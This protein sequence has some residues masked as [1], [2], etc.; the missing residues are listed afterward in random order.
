MAKRLFRRGSGPGLRALIFMALSIALIVVDQRV[1]TFH[2]FRLRISSTAA[3]P[4]ELLV[5][6][7]V[8]FVRWL[9]TSMTS[10]TNLVHENEELRVREILLQSKLQKLL[11][12][13]E[14][15]AH[16]KQLLQSTSEI[17]GRVAVARLLAVSL[18]PNLQQVIL[19]KGSHD[20][21]YAGQPV[22]DAF[23]VMGQVTG[24]GP[25]TSKVMLITDKMS[26]VPVED[27]RNGVR[28]IAVGT[29]ES[30]ELALLNV[31]LENGIQVGDLF[32]TSG[33]GLCYPVGYPVG[34]VVKIEHQGDSPTE[35]ILLSPMAHLDRTQQV[36][37]A[38]LNETDLTK[39]VQ[40]QLTAPTT[41]PTKHPHKKVSKKNSASAV[42]TDKK[43]AHPHNSK[44]ADPHASH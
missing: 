14:E 9:N 39:E 38:W 43:S 36:V 25:L 28:A 13:E 22:L 7:P 35:K 34:M 18:D 24:V 15:N 23:G 19:D 42:Q 40:E 10:Q 30:G 20:Q 4:F 32:V 21:V 41:V 16:L 5:D 12:L 1:A 44:L 17:S 37:L 33:L 27:Y 2:A 6:S 11:S 3:Y 29:G 8:H 31:P 26:A